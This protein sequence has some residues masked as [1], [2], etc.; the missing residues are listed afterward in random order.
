MTFLLPLVALALALAAPFLLRTARGAFAPSR[1]GALVLLLAAAGVLVFRSAPE[2]DRTPALIGLVLGG[3][4]CLLGEWGGGL[5]FGVAAA[6]ALHLLPATSLPAAGLALVAGTGLGALTVGG[7]TAALAAVLVV[8]ADNLGMRHSQIPA[9]AFV[10]SQT[11]LGVAI[12]ALFPVLMRPVFV[13]GLALLGGMLASRTLSEQGLLLSVGIGALAGVVL[14]FLMPDDEGESS[15]VGL[16]AVIGVGL[17]T[18][19]FG[20]GKGL[21]M[22]L[23]ALAAV[24]VLLAVENRRA[25]LALGPLVG[26]VLFR[27]L[28]EA[29]TGATRSIDIAQHYTLLALVLGLALPLLPT[30]WLKGRA[31]AP[32]SFL[33]G[34]AVLAAPPL[35]VVALGMR[36]GIG[37][38]V[39]LGVSG[40]VQAL[41]RAEV[42]GARAEGETGPT[43]H[44]PRSTVSLL[45]LALGAGLAGGTILALAWLGDES[46]LTRDA[47]VRLFAYAAVGIAIIAGALALVAR[48]KGVVQ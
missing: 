9:A 28:R 29:G 45:P 3:L 39:G 7:E 36:G 38:V 30:D 33:W 16:A 46:T 24:G 22:G 2:I 10:G 20:L 14:H 19:A 47:K 35:V 21:G 25:V 17:A 11:G 12:G 1:I 32:G 44:G 23:A 31:S 41:R 37:F 18:V 15:R 27:V 6:A 43:V 26:L 40:L 48:R 13:G 5:A 42:G 8:A 4:A 34:L